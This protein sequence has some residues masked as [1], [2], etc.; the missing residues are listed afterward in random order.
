[1]VLKEKRCGRPQII[2]K[3]LQRRNGKERGGGLG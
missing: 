2:E 3:D 1:M